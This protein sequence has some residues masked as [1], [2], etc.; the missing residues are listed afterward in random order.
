M[1]EGTSRTTRPLPVVLTTARQPFPFARARRNTRRRRARRRAL[2]VMRE[3]LQEAPPPMD[4]LEAGN[5]MT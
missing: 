1:L 5:R 2:L 3:V 4:G